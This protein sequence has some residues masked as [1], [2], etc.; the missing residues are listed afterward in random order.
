MDLVRKIDLRDTTEAFQFNR[1]RHGT[2]SELR[3][4]SVDLCLSLSFGEKTRKNFINAERCEL[5]LRE[6]FL[7][8]LT[9]REINYRRI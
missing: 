6:F 8:T 5:F 4:Y 9:K 1:A 7:Y 2:G 3:N